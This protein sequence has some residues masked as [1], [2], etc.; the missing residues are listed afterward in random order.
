M[1]KS[2]SSITNAIG[3]LNY[4]GTWNASTNTP[5][6][7]DGTGTKGD[8]YVVSVE[9]T[10]TFGGILLIFGVGDWIV[11]NGAVWQRVEGG[12]DGN[13]V[14]LS[15]SGT[16]VISDNSANAAL[17]VTQV[18]SGNALLIEDS[19]NPDATPFVVN[20]SGDVVQGSTTSYS[21]IATYTSPIQNHVSGNAT[22][23]IGL[24]NWSSGTAAKGDIAFLK[25][26]SGTI[27]TLSAVS[28]GA[29][30]GGLTFF[31]AGDASTWVRAANIL[32]EADSGTFSA[33]SMPGRLVFS[34]T[35]DGASSPTER[36]RINSAGDVGIGTTALVGSFRLELAPAAAGAALRL[37]GG[38]GGS[39]ITQ[40][41]DSAASTPWGTLTATAASI[42]LTHSAILT[43]TTNSVERVRIA[44]TGIISLGATA[45]SESLRVT[46]VASAVNYL[47]AK[48]AATASS[49]N[50]LATGSDT[51]VSF[52]VSTKGN[53]SHFFQT[54]S[55][56]SNQFVI[57]HTAS[58]VNLIQV[59]G[60]ATGNAAAMSAAGS[61]TNIDLALT[62]KGT[63]VLRF[64][65]YTAGILAQAGY[66][67]IKDAAGNTRNLLVG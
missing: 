42:N 12:A 14:N 41:T 9:G 32:A 43:F 56:G 40:F 35:A 61:D 26:L 66:I 46:P 11:Y 25:S 59:T 36:M 63:G 55:N 45:G 50:I 51:N 53:G 34:T 31:G 62:P 67:T 4:K 7:A 30:L 1:L 28:A 52:I 33:T 37:R 8:Y 57:A 16:A 39:S 64:G 18:G 10:Q 54:N 58:A 27:G 19:A 38:S 3:A 15:V 6:L 17:R 23:G 5:T 24:F 2:V 29:D 60:G 49:P 47:E 65:T 20:A 22:A 44:S 13:F 48:G 21:T